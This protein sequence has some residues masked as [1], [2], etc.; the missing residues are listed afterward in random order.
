VVAPH[1]I[2]YHARG[3]LQPLCTLYGARLFQH[4]VSYGL[5]GVGTPPYL[6][7]ES[8]ASPHYLELWDRS[9]G[10][11][12]DPDHARIRGVFKPIRRVRLQLEHHSRKV[13]LLAKAY[14]TKRAGSGL[15]RV[16]QMAYQQEEHDHK[17]QRHTYDVLSVSD[18]MYT[19]VVSQ[20]VQ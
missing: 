10:W 20:K 6:L 8:S 7:N 13:S 12:N 17:M 1:N 9:Q 15:R 4:D 16:T 2:H 14:P 11:K 5:G 3:R 18:G 19:H